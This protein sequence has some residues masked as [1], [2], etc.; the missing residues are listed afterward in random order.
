MPKAIFCPY[1]VREEKNVKIL[2]EGGLSITFIEKKAKSNFVGG[3]CGDLTGYKRCKNA[4]KIQSKYE[5]KIK[6]K[7]GRKKYNW[8]EEELR[9][10]KNLH[11]KHGWKMGYYLDFGCSYMTCFRKLQE[12]GYISKKDRRREID[13]YKKRTT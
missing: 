9:R 8:S 3:F 4:K 7:T 6:S 13:D 11:M 1:Y 12:I 10:L 5:P 2:C